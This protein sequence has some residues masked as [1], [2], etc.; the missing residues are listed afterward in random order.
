MESHRRVLWLCA[1]LLLAGCAVSGT[2]PPELPVREIIVR[3]T[4]IPPTRTPIATIVPSEHVL[5]A[6]LRWRECAVNGLD[7]REAEACLGYPLSALGGGG[8]IGTRTEDGG[9]VLVANGDVYETRTLGSDLLSRASLRKN[10]RPVRTIYDGTPFYSPHISL[11]LIDN[12]VAWE[13][14]GE[15]VQTITYGGRDLRVQ[16]G[17]DAAYRPYELNGKLI[18]IGERDGVY[19]VVYDSEQI[20][21]LFDEITIGYCCE[22]ALYAPRFGEGRYVFWGQRGGSSF[23]VEITATGQAGQ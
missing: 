22:I 16:H 21:P 7:W 6:G 20:G 23:V 11:Q 4:V 8:T 15:R 1:I 2:P 14:H 13:F 17:L 3:T 18:F 12:E 10:G 19:F 5:E 9:L